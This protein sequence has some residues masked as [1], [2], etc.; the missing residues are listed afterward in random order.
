MSSCNGDIDCRQNITINNNHSK[1]Y[2]TINESSCDSSAN[3]PPPYS[4]ISPYII[5][6]NKNRNGHNRSL[7][8]TIGGDGR[9]THLCHPFR[10]PHNVDPKRNMQVSVK[11]ISCNPLNACNSGKSYDS[12]RFV[13]NERDTLA[14]R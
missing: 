4:K 2:L 1:V 6:Q 3:K 8:K 13:S 11:D 10:K 9:R 7:R 14:G 5:A 12:N